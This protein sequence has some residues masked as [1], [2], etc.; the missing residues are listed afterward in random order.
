MNDTGAESRRRIVK[1]FRFAAACL[2]LGLIWK[3]YGYLISTSVAAYKQARGQGLFMGAVDIFPETSTKEVRMARFRHFDR[4][5]MWANHILVARFEG[6]DT[7]FVDDLRKRY[8]NEAALEGY[9]LEMREEQSKKKWDRYVG[10]VLTVRD[11]FSDRRKDFEYCRA[12]YTPLPGSNH[13]ET[14]IWLEKGGRTAILYGEF[15]S[16]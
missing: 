16:G 1:L 6:V 12:S 15:Y 5:F 8:C 9:E 14:V 10:A 7:R 11:N 2:I 13:T 3:G 4:S